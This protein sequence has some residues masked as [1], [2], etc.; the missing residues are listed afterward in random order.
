MSIF[1]PVNQKGKKQI[2][3]LQ[4]L[5][6]LMGHSKVA[7][8]GVMGPETTKAI[9]N[10]PKEAAVVMDQFASVREVA[11][12]RVPKASVNEWTKDKIIE[13]IRDIAVK[14]GVNPRLAV[15]IAMIESDLDPDAISST[16]AD[17][18]Y[19]LTAS[20]VN[21]V[22]RFYPELYRR[23]GKGRRDV[24]WNITVGVKFIKL[25]CDQYLRVNAMT[26]SV[27][28]W[29]DIYAVF[30][31]GIGNFRKLQNGRYDDQT[32]IRSLNEQARYLKAGG[33]AQYL[34]AVQSKLES[35]VV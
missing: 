23:D 5:I 11:Y 9:W 17:G 28:V 20:A 14:E 16:G 27:E 35:V 26:D 30:N 6:N 8:D 18:L 32:L 22:A 33:P 34:A 1:A 25:I 21:D 3:D 15:T 4:R 19:Q 31:L 10:L 24:L 13:T 12:P 7:V 29:T 2:V